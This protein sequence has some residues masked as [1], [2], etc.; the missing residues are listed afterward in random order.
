MPFWRTLPPSATFPGRK[1][2]DT[3]FSILLFA[4]TRK[5]SGFFLEPVQYLSFV[6]GQDFSPGIASIGKE[7]FLSG[8]ALCA[9]PDRKKNGLW[10]R[11]SGLKP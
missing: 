4:E 1:G 6:V 5:V 2:A 11:L 3:A 10:Q 9:P 7:V 8:G